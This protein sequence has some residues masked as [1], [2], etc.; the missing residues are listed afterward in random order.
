MSWSRFLA[1]SL[2]VT[3]IINPAVGC[4]YFPPGLQLPPQP[5]LL[6]I[7]L[8]GKQRHNGCEHAV[9]LR[10]LPDSVATAI[11][12]QAF[13]AWVQHADHSATEP[14]ARVSRPYCILQRYA[15]P[16][17]CWKSVVDCGELPTASTSRSA[18]ALPLCSPPRVAPAIHLDRPPS[19]PSG[20]A[21]ASTR[22]SGVQHSDLS[23]S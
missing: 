8:L 14:P 13:C 22:L 11:W 18:T 5:F 23:I 10:L 7:L 3:W 16:V 2:Q 12:T 1:V 20:P 15:C 4:H 9:C 17:D 6:P 21:T 19:W